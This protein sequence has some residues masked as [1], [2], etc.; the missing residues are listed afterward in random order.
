M[1]TT[2][3]FLVSALMSGCQTI[4]RVSTSSFA[5][6]SEPTSRYEIALTYEN[7]SGTCVG[8]TITATF[9]VHG[10]RLAGHANHSLA[11]TFTIA[12]KVLPDGTMQDARAMGPDTVRFDGSINTGKW[13][14]ERSD[15][16][17]QYTARRTA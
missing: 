15:C 12:G 9:E 10:D 3:I 1:N 7:A 13:W 11:G 6:A 8:G 4:D 17:G 5:P 2:S 14:T 16:H